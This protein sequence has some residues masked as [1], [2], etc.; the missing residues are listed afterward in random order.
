MRQHSLFLLVFCICGRGFTSGIEKK[1]WLLHRSHLFLAESNR[2]VVRLTT[3]KSVWEN[4]H[5]ATQLKDNNSARL[6]EEKKKKNLQSFISVLESSVTTE[7]D[8][9]LC[10]LWRNL[11]QLMPVKPGEM[12]FPITVTKLLIR[13]GLLG[14]GSLYRHYQ[15]VSCCEVRFTEMLSERGRVSGEWSAT[16]IRHSEEIKK[17]YSFTPYSLNPCPICGNRSSVF[18][19][20]F[21]MGKIC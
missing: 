17:S 6:S 10:Y 20:S 15:L 1:K 18:M 11:M 21:S 9:K 19:E 13:K 5:R 7:A 16:D 12:T 8:R 4:K 2:E 3:P 14:G